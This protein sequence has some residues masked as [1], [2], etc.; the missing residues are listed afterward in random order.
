MRRVEA[1][2]V[3]DVP[4]VYQLCAGSL[5]ILIVFLSWLAVLTARMP[6]V[7]PFVRRDG[8]LAVASVGLVMPTSICSSQVADG[9]SQRLNAR[10]L[11]EQTALA[12]AEGECVPFIVL[13][14]Q[15]RSRVR[16]L[17]MPCIRFCY[18][19]DGDSSPFRLPLCNHVTRFVALPH[20]EVR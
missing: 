17:V 7:T 12:E 19:E 11:R 2:Q 16:W 10:L 8:S 6:P 15:S 4:T 9:I 1:P 20:T 13:V 5:P 3:R 14:A 18:A